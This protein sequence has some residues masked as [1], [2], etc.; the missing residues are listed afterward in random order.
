MDDLRTLQTLMN[1][2]RVAR[3]SQCIVSFDEHGIT[4][5]SYGDMADR[6]RQLASGL[7]Q[8]GLRSGDYVTILA[9]TAPNG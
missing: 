1:P 3:E 8:A 4:R 7:V 5:L 9:K 6:I 2:P